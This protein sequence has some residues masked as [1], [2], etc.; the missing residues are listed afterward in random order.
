MFERE[1]RG[2]WVCFFDY[3]FILFGVV[4]GFCMDCFCLWGRGLLG[5]EPSGGRKVGE[6]G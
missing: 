2:S 3:L 6:I 4:F 1:C 5:R